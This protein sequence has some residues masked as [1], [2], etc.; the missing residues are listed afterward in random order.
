VQRTDLGDGST[1][2]A[3]GE[4]QVRQGY[5]RL[6]IAAQGALSSSSEGFS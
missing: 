1:D 4:P 3:T 6:E 5:S 2:R